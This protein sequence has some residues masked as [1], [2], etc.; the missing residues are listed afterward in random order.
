MFTVIRKNIIEKIW[1]ILK[2]HT[3]CTGWK[4]G[5][6]LQ[7]SFRRALMPLLRFCKMTINFQSVPSPPSSL[8]WSSTAAAHRVYSGC[9]LSQLHCGTPASAATSSNDASWMKVVS[10]GVSSMAATKKALRQIEHSLR[11]HMTHVP[12]QHVC[13]CLLAHITKLHT[14][15][16]SFAKNIATE[17]FQRVRKRRT[18]NASTSNTFDCSCQ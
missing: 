15:A 9:V 6:K 18:F 17:R 16:V 2:L 1:L 8:W 5:W 7:T 13:T 12:Y 14:H 4:I 11:W 3:F 10:L